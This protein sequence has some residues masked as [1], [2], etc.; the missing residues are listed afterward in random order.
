MAIVSSPRRMFSATLSTGTSMKC[1]WTMLMPRAMAS[2]GPSILTARAVEQDLAAVGRG[3]PVQDVHQRRL[4]GAV[5]AE[6]RMDLAGPDFEVDA[7]VRDDA[8]IALRDAAHLERGGG[9][10]L[11]RRTRSRLPR[12]DRD[13]LTGRWRGTGDII[14]ARIDRG[15]ALRPP[16]GRACAK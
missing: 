8:G 12:A 15:A 16:L 13:Q 1:W 5:L 2:D 7:V 11:G 9:H 14:G 6:Q 10:G 4:A 3:Q